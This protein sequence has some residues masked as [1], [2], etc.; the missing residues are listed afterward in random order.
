MIDGRPEPVVFD[1]AGRAVPV[2]DLV[3]GPGL[4][5]VLT[6]IERWDDLRPRLARALGTDR[7]PAATSVAEIDRLGAWLPP[8]PRPGK[9]LGVGFNSPV[10]AAFASS[11]PDHPPFFSSPGSALV[12]HRQP[13]R[14][15]PSFGLVHPE[16]ELAVV[17][18][19]Q[20]T[21]IDPAEALDHVFGYTL[22]DDV[23]APGLRAGDTVVVP[24]SM[25][26]ELDRRHSGRPRA[27]SG[28]EHGD[29]RVTYHLRA[30]GTDSFKPCGP[31][32]VTRD[33]IP[34]P[35]RLGITLATGDDVRIECRTERL[36]YS[37]AEVIAHASDHHTLFPG[38]IIHVGTDITGTHTLREIDYQHRIGATRTIECEAIGTLVNEIRTV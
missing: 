30:K 23:S 29:M 28:F 9:I 26:G 18:G 17:I 33:E 13:I 8:V 34:D 15:R 21:R 31:W 14:L 36:I 20:G 4:Y 32:I 1:P 10:F 6:L 24:G 3:G 38:D 25:A 7:S 5:G 27:A 19:R 11:V 16:P 22:I 35:D 37:V 12:G 2:G